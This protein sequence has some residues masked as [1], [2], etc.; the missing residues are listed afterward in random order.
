M[1]CYRKRTWHY[2]LLASRNFVDIRKGW[3]E[4][5]EALALHRAS[6]EA[7]QNQRCLQGRAQ[8][9]L[10]Q[11]IL[12]N[13]VEANA[14]AAKPNITSRTGC[15]LSTVVLLCTCRE[16]FLPL[17]RKENISKTRRYQEIRTAIGTVRS[18]K[19]ANV[20]IQDLDTPVPTRE[21]GGRC[22]LL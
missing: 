12:S 8:Y 3:T 7:P 16:R 4:Y 5:Q 14:V 1:V 17:G 18:S 21:V 15:A 20:H 2:I 10:L 9:E 13:Q 19:E 22:S 6:N 11:R